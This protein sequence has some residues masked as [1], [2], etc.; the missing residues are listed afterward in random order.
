MA[1]LK[2]HKVGTNGRIQ[3]GADVARQDDFYTVEKEDDGT[4]VLTPV[5]VV[6]TGAARTTTE[7]APTLI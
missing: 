3:L 6:T 4:I 1:A 2:L 7:D 5:E